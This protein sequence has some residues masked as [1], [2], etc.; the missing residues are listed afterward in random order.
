M[1]DKKKMYGASDMRLTTIPLKESS[2]KDTTGAEAMKPKVDMYS[3][4]KKSGFKQSS[5]MKATSD[6]PLRP[7]SSFKKLEKQTT[8]SYYEMQSL[9]SKVARLE[10]HIK[11]Q[12]QVINELNRTINDI[13]QGLRILGL[14]R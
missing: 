13:N 10:N 4:D 12:D 14:G 5:N 9:K 6:E 8:D 11:K 3:K 2:N 7:D 1:T